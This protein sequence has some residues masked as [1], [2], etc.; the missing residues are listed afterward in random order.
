LATAAK[1]LKL[2]DSL[3]VY[4]GYKVAI[5]SIYAFRNDT[6][7]AVYNLEADGNHNYYVSA[8]GVLVHNCGKEL[9][10]F[11]SAAAER[12]AN[13]ARQVPIEILEIA[14]KYG[15]KVSDPRGSRATM[16]NIGMWKN[17]TLYNLEVLYDEITN[18]IW[19]FQYN[20]IKR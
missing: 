9:F 10:N 2:G 15:K 14:I 4:A 5:D 12:M 13:P 7:T 3:F 16:Y 6:A 17:N 20:T 8:G 11:S 19:H 18:S 1:D